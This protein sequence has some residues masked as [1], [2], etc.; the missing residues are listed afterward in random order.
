[1]KI[2]ILT[3]HKNES[4]YIVFE[5]FCFLSRPSVFQTRYVYPSILTMND[6]HENHQQLVTWYDAVA[7][8]RNGRPV[9]FVVFLQVID[10]EQ[11]FGGHE[12]LNFSKRKKLY[13]LFK[14]VKLQRKTKFNKTNAPIVPSPP[15][16][17]R[18]C[19]LHVVVT[20]S[21]T[22]TLASLKYAAA[23]RR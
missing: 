14:K 23:T 9:W 7:P 10:P 13:L 8:F 4:R 20:D 5:D 1:M 15:P 17:I 3:K 18:R 19:F 6:K 2:R 16:W 22:T 11:H 12:I 21:A